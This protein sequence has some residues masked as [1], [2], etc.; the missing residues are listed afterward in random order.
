MW[1][2]YL[3]GNEGEKG[4][5]GVKG[6]Q[7]MLYGLFRFPASSPVP[8]HRSLGHNNKLAVSIVPTHFF[9]NQE[10]PGVSK[11]T[12]VGALVASFLAVTGEH[13]DGAT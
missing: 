9:H 11:G 5:S 7:I 6:E 3:G 13:G 4:E 1:V 8:H 2:G 12:S 10:G